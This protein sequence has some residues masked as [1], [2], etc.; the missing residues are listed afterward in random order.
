MLQRH[1]HDTFHARQGQEYLKQ[2]YVYLLHLLLVI[3]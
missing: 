2:H 3:N 1:L